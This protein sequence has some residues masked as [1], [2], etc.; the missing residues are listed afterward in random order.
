MDSANDVPVNKY[1]KLKV[2]SKLSNVQSWHIHVLGPG[3]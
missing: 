1:I 3:Y 2:N